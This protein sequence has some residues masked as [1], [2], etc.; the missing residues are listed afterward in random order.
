M[1]NCPVCGTYFVEG[2]SGYFGCCC[3]NCYEKHTDGKPWNRDM[4]EAGIDLVFKGIEAG[5]NFLFGKKPKSSASKS[6]SSSSGY[7]MTE[8]ERKRQREEQNRRDEERKEREEQERKEWEGKEITTL[9]DYRDGR[10]YQGEIPFTLDAYH[11]EIDF[12]FDLGVKEITAEFAR[13]N[14]PGA[15]MKNETKKTKILNELEKYR[16]EQKE[17]LRLYFDRLDSGK[18]IDKYKIKI[19]L[20]EFRR[21]ASE[22][23][24]K[25]FNKAYGF[26][27]SNFIGKKPGKIIRAAV[28]IPVSII[29]FCLIFI[30]Q[31]IGIVWGS[32]I[33]VA[34]MAEAM[35]I[36]SPSDDWGNRISQIIFLPILGGIGGIIVGG[37]AWILSSFWTFIMV[38]WAIVMI[39]ASL[40]LIFMEELDK[41]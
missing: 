16:E 17:K 1:A 30:F 34:I 33:A 9:D 26:I 27:D 15:E 8:A 11:E 5:A 3:K 6:G 32:I 31:R 36:T 12:I 18:K 35:A 38:T 4:A 2:K 24:Y 37:I 41:L 23:S 14:K 29:F 19:T 25:A 28:C 21:K 13:N 10:E 40:L 39:G 22:L 20:I 7:V